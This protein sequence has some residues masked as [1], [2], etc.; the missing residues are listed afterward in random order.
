MISFVSPS[1]LNSL[2]CRAFQALL[3]FLHLQLY[4]CY[5]W[6]CRTRCGIQVRV[7]ASPNEFQEG[8]AID[9][10]WKTGEVLKRP[11]RRRGASDPWWMQEAEKNNKRILPKYKP[12]WV[13]HNPV[14]NATWSIS[15]LKMEALRRNIPISENKQVLLNSLIESTNRYD[16][17]DAAYVTPS[18]RVR[19]STEPLPKCYPESYEESGS[20]ESLRQ[21]INK[22]STNK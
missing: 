19:A 1:K 13:V 21:I 16:L 17:T 9:K 3:L 5:A 22:K 12:W 2:V 11:S 4:T 18:Y 15:K 20:I 7:N 10:A 14:V 8:G 6:N